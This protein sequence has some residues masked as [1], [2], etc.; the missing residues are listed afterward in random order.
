MLKSNVV[1]LA[2]AA[3]TASAC[4]TAKP[5]DL[6]PADGHRT[7][8]EGYS[9]VYGIASQQK[10]M[11]KLLW[12]KRESDPVDKVISAIADYTGELTTQLE[13]MAK[14]Y[15][16]LTVQTQFLPTVEVKMR[17]SVAAATTK[18][19]L[20]SSGK[21]FERRLL[22]KQLTALETEQH[23]SKV[24]VELETAD[25]RRAFWRGVEKRF[26]ELRR[27]VE[28]LLQREYFCG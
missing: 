28:G 13:D 12:I 2:L 26:G 18:E 8:A 3:L 1:V 24:M 19:F 6:P 7:V 11:K 16:A 21:D 23:L 25:E 5:Q 20:D 14:R 10:D 15:P 27:D 9:L 4:S 17:E 22:L